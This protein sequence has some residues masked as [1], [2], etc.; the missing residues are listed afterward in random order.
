MSAID[1]AAVAFRAIIDPQSHNCDHR[2]LGPELL[3]Y[4][5]VAE[6]LSVA[7]GRPI[8]HVKLSGD[9][10]YEGLVSVGV[11]EYYA[12]F[13][14]NLETAASTGFETRMNAAVEKV[15]GRAPR[16]LDLFAHDNRGAWEPLS[17]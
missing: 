12:R 3:T 14:T 7:L 13:L 17:E 5:E 15:T 11:S 2:V 8:E 16:T 4:D 6:K 1:I 10:R 9:Q